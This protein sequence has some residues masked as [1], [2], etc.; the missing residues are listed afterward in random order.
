LKLSERTVKSH[1]HSIYL[2]LGVEP[3]TALMIGWANRSRAD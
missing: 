1:L 3:R 2:K